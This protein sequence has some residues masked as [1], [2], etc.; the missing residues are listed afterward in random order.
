MAINLPIFPTPQKRYNLKTLENEKFNECGSGKVHKLRD[1]VFQE[2]GWI[3][4]ECREILWGRLWNINSLYNNK[5]IW[6]LKIEIE[7]LQFFFVNFLA[8]FNSELIWDDSKSF[9][10]WLIFGKIL[11]KSASGVSLDGYSQA[12]D[13]LRLSKPLRT[14]NKSPALLYPPKTAFFPKLIT[15]I[16]D[17]PQPNPT[18]FYLETFL[19]IFRDKSHLI[20]RSNMFY[21]TFPKAHKQKTPSP[22]SETIMPAILTLYL[23]W[24]YLL[25]NT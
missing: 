13:F 22:I 23:L 10:M 17:F 3:V 15:Q 9:P 20:P 5:E 4:Y 19:S 25:C 24:F 6:K 2:L 21:R 7:N 8:N 16:Q 12:R 18:N 14:I 11:E 1:F